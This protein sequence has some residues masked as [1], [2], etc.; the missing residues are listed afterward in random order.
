M[1]IS[2]TQARLAL[3]CLHTDEGD[4]GPGVDD[5]CMRK[6]SPELLERVKDVLRDT[7]DLRPDRV[8][9]ARDDIAESRYSSAD[10]ASKIIARVISDSL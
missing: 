7:P 5:A 6:V 4:G 8:A 3:S 10:V 9:Q 2:D 1:I